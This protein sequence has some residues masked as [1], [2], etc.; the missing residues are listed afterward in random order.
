MVDNRSIDTITITTTQPLTDRQG[1]LRPWQVLFVVNGTLCSL[2]SLAHPTPWFHSCVCQPALFLKE[3]ASSLINHQSQ[4][5]CQK[6][7]FGMC[8]QTNKQQHKQTRFLAFYQDK[9]SLLAPDTIR[10]VTSIPTVHIDI[11]TNQ[12]PTFTAVSN[13][14]QTGEETRGMRTATQMSVC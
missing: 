7:L 12:S 2:Y 14:L 5:Y 9:V 8:Q 13:A 10:K 1:D 4:L 6:R 3:T 11:H